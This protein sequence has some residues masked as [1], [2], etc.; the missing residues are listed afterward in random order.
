MQLEGTKGVASVDWL[1]VWFGVSADGR[2][3]RAVQ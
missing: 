3:C 1:L 2:R